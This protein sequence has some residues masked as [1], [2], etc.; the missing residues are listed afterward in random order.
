MEM[1]EIGLLIALAVCTAQALRLLPKKMIPL[2]R[3]QAAALTLIIA[4]A[5]V[6]MYD[7]AGLR[8]RVQGMG[9]TGIGNEPTVTQ[10]ITFEAEGSATT[11]SS[12]DAAN[13]TFICSFIENRAVLDN[14]VAPTSPYA[15]ITTVTF[16]ITVFRTDLLALG[17]NAVS[18]ISVTVPRY[19]GKAGTDN[20]SLQYAA[21]TR[22]SD[23]KWNVA[24]TPS[25]VA[26]RNGYNYFTVGNGG[27]K[28]IALTA[29]ISNRGLSQLDNFQSTTVP[30][31]IT[32][33]SG[34][35]YLRFVK[36]GEI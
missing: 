34:D 17:E 4:L 11:N 8:T 6:G 23:D 30:I 20:E 28:A 2:N 27:S 21:I 7:W 31:S 3:R 18:K 14:I 9:V 33:L 1:L 26:A 22:T 29:T 19:Y 24:I 35:F 5:G 15:G 25:G 32:G 16:T 36:V 10:G 13:R 12:Y